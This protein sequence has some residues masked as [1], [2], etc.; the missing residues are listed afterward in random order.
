MLF[1]MLKQHQNFEQLK[2]DTE[3]TPVIL[4][5]KVDVDS[6]TYK[7]IYKYNTIL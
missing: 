3:A 1:L 7:I 6:E 4:L 5:G 2:L